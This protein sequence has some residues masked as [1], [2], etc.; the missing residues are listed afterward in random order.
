MTGIMKGADRLA[1]RCR[2]AA[3]APTQGRTLARDAGVW[4][5][6]QSFQRRQPACACSAAGCGL[7]TIP[8]QSSVA[9]AFAE[10]DAGEGRMKPSPY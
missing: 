4:A 1:A 9:R 10:F 2:W 5:G 6:S 7:V 8:N 3:C